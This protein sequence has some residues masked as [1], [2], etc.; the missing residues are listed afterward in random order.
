MTFLIF[1]Q[2]DY[3]YGYILYAINRHRS[4]SIF[5][6]NRAY[7]KD[8]QN[9]VDDKLGVNSFL[10]QPIQRLPKYKLLLM[11][12][13]TELAKTLEEEGIKVQI[14]ACCTAEKTLQRLLDTVN[15]SMNINDILEC[16]DVSS[17]PDS[18]L[19]RTF[20][21]FPFAFDFR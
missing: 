10:V 11:Q 6:E 19:M 8:Y 9:K 13:I 2:K 7:L 16:N 20:Q 21:S 1:L 3:F 12:L 5:E 17:S 14:A 15:E 18:P 4:E